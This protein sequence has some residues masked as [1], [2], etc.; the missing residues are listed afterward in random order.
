M[1]AK[2]KH[3]EIIGKADSLDDVL[4]KERALLVQQEADRLIQEMKQGGYVSEPAMPKITKVDPNAPHPPTFLERQESMKPVRVPTAIPAVDAENPLAHLDVTT[5]E[6]ESLPAA[7]KRSLFRWPK[8][9][10]L[11]PKKGEKPHAY[12][13]GKIPAGTPEK[14]E[15]GDSL[16]RVAI[17]DNRLTIQEAVD[18]G[19]ANNIQMQA[20]KKN[21]EVADAK[22]SEAKRGLFPTL[23]TVMDIHG[24]KVPGTSGLRF[25][26][27]RGN[28]VNM[29]QP[30]YYG[31]ELT[32]TVKQ[33]E[34]NL[35]VAKAE[36]KKTKNDFIH[37]T[38]LTYYGLIKAEYNAQYQ[39]ELFE[40]IS[41]I[42]KQV[43][44]EAVQKLLPEVD[45][46]NVES[47]YYQT[48]YQ[49]ES[50]KNDV[51]SAN[52]GLKQSMNV[53]NEDILPV[54]LKIQFFKVR[55]DFN[56]LLARAMDSNADVRI[57]VYA[58]E[59]AKYGVD[60]YQSKKK[61]HFEL[62]SSY[63]M[64]GEEFHDDIA[65]EDSQADPDTEKEWFLGVH[66]SMPLGTNSLE[67][68]QIKHTYAP[69]VSAFRGS[70]D[71][72]H[73]VTFN[74]FDKMSA[75]TDEKTAQ[76]ALL[77]AEGEYQAS[78]NEVTLRLRD[79]YYSLQKYLIQIDSSIAKIRY[80]DKQN[81]ILEYMLG[82][83][84]AMPSNY[85]ENLIEQAQ[86]KYAFIQAVADYNVSLSSLAVLMGDPDY[87]DNQQSMS[88]GKDNVLQV[89][90]V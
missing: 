29:T 70:E 61:P 6:K 86:N 88:K 28:K 47:Q 19:I 52:V 26:K 48:L 75:V 49:V 41:Q 37:Q 73:R 45:A 65:F 31:G 9:R 89:A 25:F 72:S 63:G 16:Y 4:E 1:L 62:R 46:L 76:Y 15:D 51:L 40:K 22:L 44:E 59:A 39:I 66:G 90:N 27:G 68:E 56:E 32:N 33:A 71:W 77:Q 8:L 57:R 54:D 80:Q 30:L 35:Q 79:D 17:S 60:I 58:L 83:Q 20:A 87:F 7:T 50:S 85:V 43:K 34:E 2:Q 78:R 18:I 3:Q 36:Y 82:L 74:L 23:Q 13:Q 53:D 14:I 84:E 24:G 38:R 64:L 42:F 67:Y 69:T 81:G 12:G 55:P 11:F 10:S 21:V 5:Q